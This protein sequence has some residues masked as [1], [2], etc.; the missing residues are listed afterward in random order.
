MFL[1]LGLIEKKVV[2]YFALPFLSFD[3][4]K[5]TKKTLQWQM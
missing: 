3:I 2:H 4:K 5:I 1:M